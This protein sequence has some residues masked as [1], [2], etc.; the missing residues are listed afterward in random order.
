MPLESGGFEFYFH[1]NNSTSSDWQ[2][3]NNGL[4]IDSATRYEA[5]SLI[6]STA[7]KL[8]VVELSAE[9]SLVYSWTYSWTTSAK[10]S[11]PED[12]VSF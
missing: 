6:Q 7:G 5:V 2:L 1:D 4:P 8:E 11:E 9:G 12:F 10:W 3:G